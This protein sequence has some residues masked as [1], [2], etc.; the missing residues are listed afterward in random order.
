GEN[1]REYMYQNILGCDSAKFVLDVAVWPAMTTTEQTDSLCATYGSFT[2]SL[3]SRD[4]IITDFV[5][6]ENHREYMYQNILGC[7]SAKFVLDVAVWPAMTTTEQTDSLCATYGSFTWSLGS[8]DSIITDF[9]IGENHREY[10]YQNILGCDS[11]KFV[12]DVAVWPAMTTTE[13]T[14]SLCATYGSFTWSLGSR[15]S[16]ITD[17]VIGEN[18][19]EYMYQNILGCDSAK[20]VLDVAVWPAA[21]DE[22]VKY[23][24]ILVDN[25]PYIWSTYTDKT[26]ACYTA[27]TYRDTAFNIL[28]CDSIR[29]TL[30]LA[31]IAHDTVTLPVEADLCHGETYTSRWQE[32]TPRFVGDTT[33]S[34][35]VPSIMMNPLLMRDSVYAYTIHVQS[36]YVDELPALVKYDSWLLVVDR[37]GIEDKGITFTAD[38]VLWYRVEDEVDEYPFGENNDTQIGTGDY[39][40]IAEKM[41]GQYYALI[42]VDVSWL[43]PCATIARTVILDCD[44][45]SGSGPK[46]APNI[47]PVGG[48]MTLSNLSEGESTISIYTSAGQLIRNEKVNG[49]TEYLVHAEGASGIYLLQVKSEGK[50]DV[51]KYIITH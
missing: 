38:Q 40:T 17:F 21:K 41:S 5:I 28:G 47:V 33:F 32:V 18:H 50:Q 24:T 11:A 30:E 22:P 26:I 49:L 20:F 14:D 10:M 12:L 6:G 31:I 3:G 51:F 13:Q 42:D 23:D 29:Y 1:H 4:S 2:W 48:V 37:K 15:D 34:D 19:R 25:L 7:D 8:R 43:A 16:I 36:R 44:A 39:Y 46:L 45:P 9:V 27:D 35:T